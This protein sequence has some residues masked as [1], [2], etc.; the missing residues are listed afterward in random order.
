M[1]MRV[2]VVVVGLLAGVGGAAP[3]WAQG[4]AQPGVLAFG[5][6]EQTTYRVQY[7]GVTAGEAQVTVGA[8]T[9]QFGQEVVPLVALARTDENVGVWPIK[10]RF[11]SYFSPEHGKVLGSDLFVDENRKRRRQRIR[12]NPDGRSAQ[13]VKQKEGER[14]QEAQHTVPENVSDVAGA[15]FLLRNQELVV[16]QT[17]EVPVFTGS[18][19]FV[20]RAKVEG[21]Q[22]LATPMG[23]REVFRLRVKTQFDG[24]LAS[25]R[26]IVAYLTT[27]PS[28]L[29]VRI[30]A[31][32]VVGQIVAEL[33][34]YKQGRALASRAGLNTGG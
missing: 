34:E 11:V 7:L 4:A 14:P 3:G 33:K 16:G 8:P 17:Y 23:P 30:E 22:Q 21:K 12:L 15:T 13:V 2:S 10:D 9:R 28:H 20:L 29:P 31:D 26:D 32:F 27:D 18:K 24:K 19:T 6:G 5:P 1:S 25:K